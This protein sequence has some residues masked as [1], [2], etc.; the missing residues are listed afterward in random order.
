M[1]NANE[2]LGDGG[3]T[4]WVADPVLLA[5]LAGFGVRGANWSGP[6]SSHAEWLRK[7]S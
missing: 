1:L 6:P 3:K 7:F 5:V 2:A 4:R